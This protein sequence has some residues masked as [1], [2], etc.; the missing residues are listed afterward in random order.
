M[1]YSVRVGYSIIRRLLFSKY[2]MGLV[3]N[4]R[5]VQIVFLVVALF[6]CVSLSYDFEVATADSPAVVVA[7]RA[8]AQAHQKVEQPVVRFLVAGLAAVAHLALHVFQ[9]QNADFAVVAVAQRFRFWKLLTALG[10]LIW[11]IAQQRVV[12][13][14]RADPLYAF[15]A[16]SAMIELI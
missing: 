8:A 7:L 1:V 2:V 10:V 4:G 12:P 3:E 11:F 13:P 15:R 16:V 5:A 6:V 14:K 9:A